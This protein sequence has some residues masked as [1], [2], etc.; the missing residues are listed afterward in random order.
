MTKIIFYHENRRRTYISNNDPSSLRRNNPHTGLRFTRKS[1]SVSGIVKYYTVHVRNGKTI[2]KKTYVGGFKNDRPH[3]LGIL[4]GNQL[5][6]KGKFNKGKRISGISRLNTNHENKICYTLDKDKTIKYFLDGK[7]DGEVVTLTID[8][9]K[10]LQWSK[11]IT[12]NTIEKTKTLFGSFS[13]KESDG[14]DHLLA[15][16]ALININDNI[17]QYSNDQDFDTR[18][19]SFGYQIRKFKEFVEKYKDTGKVI[20]SELYT[21]DH[22]VGII[23][24]D[25][26]FLIIDTSGSIYLDKEA[27]KALQLNNIDVLAYNSQTIGNCIL[28]SRVVTNELANDISN[29]K[30]TMDNLILYDKLKKQ[31][32]DI[33]T[34]EERLHEF[35]NRLN[36]IR[37]ENKYLNLLSYSDGEVTITYDNCCNGEGKIIFP[38]GKSYEG[39]LK[40]GK[41]NGEGKVTYQNGSKYKGQFKDGKPNGSGTLICANG[42]V[43]ECQFEDGKTV[44]KE[45]IIYKN[46]DIYRSESKDSELIKK[47]NNNDNKDKQKLR[48]KVVDLIQQK[49]ELNKLHVNTKTNLNKKMQIKV[50]EALKDIGSKGFGNTY[51]QR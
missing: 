18:Q 32:E 13:K 28:A 35:I 31:A 10:K 26:K 33:K 49:Q 51:H 11:N 37:D 5:D 22:A 24:K 29:G 45:K 23:Y 17:V 16:L 2:F 25:G 46:D 44:S 14:Y 42:D 34:K 15:N 27:V 7:E 21:E 19:Y 8:K 38:S 40:D 48:P 20:T 1:H 3:N 12:E 9:D 50:M 36:D 41:P 43:Y 47:T 6:F 30:N 4:H 39:Q